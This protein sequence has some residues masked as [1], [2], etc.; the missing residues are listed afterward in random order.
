MRQHNM[1]TK[2]PATKQKKTAAT[3]YI[4]VKGATY[5]RVVGE[6]LELDLRLDLIDRI[7]GLVAEGKYVSRGDAIRSILREF[8][9]NTEK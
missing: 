6:T 2:K 4:T 8:I 9:N 3:D 7:D 5:E 1:A